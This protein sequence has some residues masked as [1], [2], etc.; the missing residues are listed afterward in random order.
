VTRLAAAVLALLGLSAGAAQ[1]RSEGSFRLTSPAFAA[2]ARIPR[3]F[4][5]DG[6]QR[7]VPLRW[8]G[9]PPATRSFALLVDDPDAPSGTF[10]HRLAW[11]I[12]G[13]ARSL[14]GR[15]PREGRTSAGN[16]GWVGPCPPSGVHRYVFKL[17]ALRTP[18]RLA[19]GAD[20]TAFLAAL[21][22]RVLATATLIG[23]YGR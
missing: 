8:R 22:G 4:T 19:A 10:T 13:A 6:A 21:R 14:A 5:C 17:Y 11:A 7:I 12:P 3:S 18:L 1:A 20:P 15:A 16:V 2:G 23:R 9:A